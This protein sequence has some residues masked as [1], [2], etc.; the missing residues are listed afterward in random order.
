M[1][2]ASSPPCWARVM[3]PI[4]EYDFFLKMSFSCFGFFYLE[5]FLE[6]SVLSHEKVKKQTT[7]C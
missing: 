7:E 6:I 4:L 5:I 1:S 3:F 2:A